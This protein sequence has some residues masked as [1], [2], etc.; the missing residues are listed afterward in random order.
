MIRPSQEKPIDD[1]RASIENA[2]GPA[3]EFKTAVEETKETALPA[4]LTV[5]GVRTMTPGPD[6]KVA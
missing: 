3:E 4:K 5:V 2:A 1:A 6:K